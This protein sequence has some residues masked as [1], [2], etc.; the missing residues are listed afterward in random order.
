VQIRVDAEKFLAMM[1]KRANDLPAKRRKVLVTM[2][3]HQVRSTTQNFLAKGRK[4]E[5]TGVW[6]PLA[7]STIAGR[8]RGQRKNPMPLVRTGILRNSIVPKFEEGAEASTLKVGTNVPYAK[9]HQQ[10]GD[11]GDVGSFFL[12]SSQ[13]K[14]L[15]GIKPGKIGSIEDVSLVGGNFLG[16]AAAHLRQSKA[17]RALAQKWKKASRASMV[18]GLDKFIRIKGQ[19]PKRVFLRWHKADLAFFK[20]MCFKEFGAGGSR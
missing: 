13:E 19:L 3:W 20:Q 18:A 6:A 5:A 17:D 9:W 16:R 11:M 14:T 8:K 10:D 4:D 15:R 2:G 7:T 1:R 12:S